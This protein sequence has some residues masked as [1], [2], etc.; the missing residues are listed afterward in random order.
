MRHRATSFATLLTLAAGT[1]FSLSVRAADNTTW[2]DDPDNRGTEAAPI[3]IYN[4]AKWTSGALPSSNYNLNFTA[5]GLTYITNST[6]KQIATALRFLGGDFV[7]FGPMKFASF[8]LNASET[9]P[10]SIDKRG[11]WS[12]D[13]NFL[14]ATKDGSSFALTNTAGN[15]LSK[16]NRLRI[17]AG[18][19]T[20][21]AFVLQNGALTCLNNN[22]YVGYGEGSIARF[23]QNGGT[24]TFGERLQ[25]AYGTNSTAVF[26]LNGGT[27][28]V[29]ND[30]YVGYDGAGELT[31]NNGEFSVGGDTWLG[32]NG[33]YS[34]GNINLNG[35]TFATSYIRVPNSKGG[36]T[37]TF[38][39][40][41]LK[42]TNM[43]DNQLIQGDAKIKVRIGAQGGTIDTAG[44][45]IRYPKLT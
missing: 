39:G 11:N 21:S 33:G 4:A 27:T 17:G 22:C 37:I 43:S 31:I 15:L 12:G 38:N 19:N 23:E 3:D 32:K 26:T 8:G 20:T 9:A 41:T 10:V 7:V 6:T 36:G 2:K 25:I 16:N 42:A 29:T 14:I 44:F 13:G 24:V 1:M 40:G 30:L 28:C 35:G 34:S 18:N 45:E 5:G